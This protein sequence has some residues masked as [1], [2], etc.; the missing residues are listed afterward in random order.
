MFC[1]RSVRH[2]AHHQLKFKLRRFTTGNFLRKEETNEDDGK[3]DEILS[4]DNDYNIIAENYFSLGQSHNCL[5]IQP[6]VK[7]GP[8]KKQNITPEEQLDEATALIKTLPNWNV[9]DTIGI[10]LDT[11]ERKTLFKSGSMDK[12]VQ[13]I[14]QRSD[15]SAIF[16]NVGNLRNIQ[17]GLLQENLG[18]P[19]LDRYQIVMQILKLH[20]TSKHAKLQVA[21][22]ELYYIQKKAQKSALFGTSNS[23]AV[24]LMFQ[25]REA[26]LKTAI[27]NLR[28]QR[29]LL[30]NK[31]KK[32]DYPVVAVVGYTNAGKTSL[33]KAL[34]GDSRL[35][36]KNQL[37][38]TLDV[39]L[40][41][42]IL[43]SGLEVLYVDTV[44]FIS[45][46]PTNLIECF[47]ATL[48]DAVLA[49]VILH[50]E[51]LASTNF[52]FKRSHVLNTLKDLSNK[53]EVGDIM[54][55]VVSVGNKCDIG[56]KTD[57][58]PLN[59]SSVT[60]EGLDELRYQLE[61]A[62]L[63]ATSRQKLTIKIPNGGDEL[64]WLYKNSTIISEEADE[65]NSQLLKV[66]I[67]ITTANLQKFKH[68]YLKRR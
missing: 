24:K 45:D 53:A 12:L 11:L 15:V 33:I 39:T 2:F 17:V 54:A 31:R 47:V 55:K 37:F 34:T 52:E 25:K 8:K 13:L 1:L 62:I 19:I 6:Y 27:D 68:N 20:A 44:G 56:H 46:I 49:D 22:A 60:S 48:E 26:K 58:S 40:H 63:K 30:R 38:A 64:R 51:D 59:V 5:I 43:P 4:S 29:A 28:S 9:L 32:M 3:I 21:L 66:K 14:R 41:S 65:E 36:P 57:L 35:T 18:R 23:D 7:W 67:I 50:V 10:P 61:A 42:G 16:M